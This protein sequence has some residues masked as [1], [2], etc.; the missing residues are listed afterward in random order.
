MERPQRKQDAQ[1]LREQLHGDAAGNLPWVMPVALLSWPAQSKKCELGISDTARRVYLMAYNLAGDQW[2]EG[3]QLINCTMGGLADWLCCDPKSVSRAFNCLVKIGLAEPVDAKRGMHGHVLYKIMDVRT[4]AREHAFAAID[5]RRQLPMELADDEPLL[6]KYLDLTDD[7]ERPL[8]PEIDTEETGGDGDTSAGLFGGAV[9]E[10]GGDG[11]NA[12]CF[13]KGADQEFQNARARLLQQVTSID[14]DEIQPPQANGRADCEDVSTSND[15][16]SDVHAESQEGEKRRRRFALERLPEITEEQRA[17][18]AAM[19]LECE[20]EAQDAR[21][22]GTRHPFG[23]TDPELKSYAKLFRKRLQRDGD[24]R[25]YEGFC[26]RVCALVRDGHLPMCEINRCIA[27][28]RENGDRGF[29]R[30][31][32]GFIKVRVNDIGLKWPEPKRWGAVQ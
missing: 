26:I 14:R 31:F 10:T 29:G 24:D 30:A 2:R 12:A 13:S 15:I 8:F 5:A 32:A 7:V 25:A 3:K 28:A 16:T 11:D 27:C 23:V 22:S 19:R 17:E 21:E 1:Q 9:L 6:L 20:L 4:V 18:A